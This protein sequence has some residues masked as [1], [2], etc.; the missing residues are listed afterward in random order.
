M[1]A[2]PFHATPSTLSKRTFTLLLAPTGQL[3]GDGQLR[4]LFQERRERHAG[5]GDLWYLSAPV[6]RV[7]GQGA[8][9]H[10]A[11][12]AVDPAVITWL[13]LRFGGIRRTVVLN[14]ALLEERADALPPAAPRRPLCP[15]GRQGTPSR[16]KPWALICSATAPWR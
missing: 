4:E 3:S 14:T 5:Q 9:G 11:V 2:H 16:C 13:Q 8:A 15:R 12:V 10:E 1:V 6:V 7:L